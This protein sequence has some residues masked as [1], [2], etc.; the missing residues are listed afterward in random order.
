M[1]VDG[2]ILRLEADMYEIV[3]HHRAVKA[4]PTVLGRE[5]IY[6]R[7]HKKFLSFH[8]LNDLGLPWEGD[9]VRDA[10]CL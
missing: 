9:Q 8:T 3:E 5:P 7:I 10:T 2:H 4:E 1:L 6:L